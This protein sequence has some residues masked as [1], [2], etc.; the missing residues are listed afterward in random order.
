MRSLP[1]NENTKFNNYPFNAFFIAIL[2][3]N[4]IDITN[5]LFSNYIHLFYQKPR[6]DFKIDILGN[7]T[8]E[9][10][11]FITSRIP[12]NCINVSFLKKNIDE[13][14]YIFVLINEKYISNESVGLSFDYCHDW[15]IYGYDDAKSCFLCSGYVGKDIE[16]RTFKSIWLKYDD[17]KKGME[18]VPKSYLRFKSKSFRNHTIEINQSWNEPIRDKDWLIKELR[19]FY[20]IDKNFSLNFFSKKYDRRAL[21][22]FEKM[23]YKNHVNCSKNNKIVLSNFRTLYENKQVLL[24]ALKMI[25]D[26]D[27]DIENYETLVREKY[28]VLLLAAKYNMTF[29]INETFKIYQMLYTNRKEEEKIFFKYIT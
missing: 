15:L 14:K 2:E 7:G 23:F 16:M 12:K 5:L 3:A 1:Y 28:V 8:I 20:G 4:N 11:R 21:I 29:N 26:N 6:K 13:G 22:K 27:E 17:V 9:K 25:S 19:L 24:K 10:D 18:M